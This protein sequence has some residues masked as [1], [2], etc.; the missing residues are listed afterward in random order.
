M[1][2]EFMGRFFVDQVDCG[3]EGF[4]IGEQVGCFFEYFYLVVD[5]YVIECIVCGVVDVVGC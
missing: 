4:C 1:V 3:V 5:G 2:F